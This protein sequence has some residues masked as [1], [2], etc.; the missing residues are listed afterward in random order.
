M[1]MKRKNLVPVDWVSKVI[2][3]VVSKDHWHGRSYHLTPGNRV[4]VR[5]IAAVTKEAI[6][7]RYGP[8]K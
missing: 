8:K 3:H 5:E 4:P 2:T 7:Q 6:M 1:V